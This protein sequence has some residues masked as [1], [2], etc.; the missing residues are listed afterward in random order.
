[1]GQFSTETSY[2][3]K[4]FA[5]RMHAIKGSETNNLLSLIMTVMMGLV[6][7][8]E[9]LD[10]GFDDIGLLRRD[11]VQINLRQCCTIPCSKTST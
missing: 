6:R 8:I 2:K 10:R 4:T 9:E 7:K 11:A 1:M 3:D 5:F